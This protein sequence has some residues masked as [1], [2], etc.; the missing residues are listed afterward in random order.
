[1]YPFHRENNDK[2]SIPQKIEVVLVFDPTA[3]GLTLRKL[4]GHDGIMGFVRQ[5]SQIQNMGKKL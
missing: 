5:H 3:K 2:Y 4:T 1:M